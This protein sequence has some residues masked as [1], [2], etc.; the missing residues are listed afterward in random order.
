MSSPAQSVAEAPQYSLTIR[1]WKTG[2]EVEPGGGSFS[3]ATNAKKVELT[4]IPNLDELPN[5]FA[6]RR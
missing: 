6:V 1:D 3:N 5:I 4:E 2:G